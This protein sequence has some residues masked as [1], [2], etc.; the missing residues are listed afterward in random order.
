MH[1]CWF[2]MNL[3]CSISHS[4]YSVDI[5]QIRKRNASLVRRSIASSFNFSQARSTIP[6]LGQRQLKLYTLFR[7]AK[8]KIISCPAARTRIIQIREYPPSPGLYSFPN[9]KRVKSK[10]SFIFRNEV[11]GLIYNKGAESMFIEINRTSDRNVFA[12]IA[13]RPPNQNLNELLCDL[14]IFSIVFLKKIN[15]FSCWATG[16]WI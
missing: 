9:I 12:R 2:H 14:D 8:P 3:N 16:M 1:T 15:L 7:T 6:C 4:V 5:M 10:D 13:Y 11:L